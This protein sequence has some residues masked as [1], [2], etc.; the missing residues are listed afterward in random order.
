MGLTLNVAV[1]L[2]EWLRRSGGGG[3]LLSFGAQSLQFDAPAFIAATG[4]RAFSGTAQS[5][6]AVCGY[7]DNRALDVSGFEG[8]EIIFD[9][10]EGRTPADLLGG[11]DA[12]F[13]G[14]TIEHVFHVPNALAHVT[15]LLRPDGLAIHLSPC[16]N[17]VDHGFY[18][19]SPTLFFDYYEAAGFQPLES[20]VFL[21]ERDVRAPWRVMP[22]PPHAFGSGL[23]GT[24]DGR[25]GLQL[26]MARKTASAVD[27]AV[28]TQSLYRADRRGI[29]PQ[30]R[31]F[32]PFTMVDGRVADATR[33]VE[34]ILGPFTPDRGLSWTCQVAEW[35]DRSDTLADPV[36]S[37]VIVMEDGVM[38]G[39]AHSTHDHIRTEGGGRFSHW[40]TTIYLSTPDGT[41]PNENGRKYVA[42]APGDGPAR[43]A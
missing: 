30:P 19:F 38:M 26:F 33:Y 34:R 39:P 17:W 14:G 28:P 36:R 42:M 3:R 12:V 6:F 11:F 8:A 5:Y 35:H 23:S 43:L 25:I 41:N 22:A 1:V 27:V 31:W 4:E 7:P 13:N 18:Q 20:A 16:H 40:G 15:R 32:P 29:R 24:F 9:L 10:N 21:F 37:P 2:H